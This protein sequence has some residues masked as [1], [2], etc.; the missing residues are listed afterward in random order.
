MKYFIFVLLFF[1]FE[2]NI[3]PQ[4]YKVIS[5]QPNQNE[6]GAVVN[7]LIKVKLSFNPDSSY[8]NDHSFNV[9]GSV[10]GVHTGKVELNGSENELVFTSGTKYIIG[11][12]VSVCFMPMYSG[13]IRRTKSFNWRFTIGAAKKTAAKFSTR[14]EPSL[15]NSDF[16]PVDYDHNG[17]VD[18][19]TPSGKVFYNDGKGNFPV[20]KTHTELMGGVLMPDVNNDGFQDIFN[21]EGGSWRIRFGNKDG[22]YFDGEAVNNSQAIIKRWGDFNGDGYIDVIG[23]TERRFRVYFNDGKGNFNLDT[24]AIENGENA[25]YPPVDVDNDGDLDLILLGWINI[26]VCLNNGE[27]KFGSVTEYKTLGKGFWDD[28]DCQDFNADGFVDAATI[29]TASGGTLIFNDKKGGYVF[30]LADSAK[31]G[32]PE[33]GGFFHIGDF[34]A[35]NK[36]DII[37][38]GVF[39]PIPW[40]SA[41]YCFLYKNL[42][43]Y[44]FTSIPPYGQPDKY[45]LSTRADAYFGN[46]CAADIDCDGALDFVHACYPTLISINGEVMT[47]VKETVQPGKFSLQQN[48]PNPF[49]PSTEIKYELS[50]AG[51]VTLKIYD[52]LGR[53]A[54]V[55]VNSYKNPGEYIEHFNASGLSSGVYICKLQA[56]NLTACKKMVLIK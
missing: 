29:S 51:F 21:N 34:N 55:L 16:I 36:P 20:V 13:A 52:I 24:T 15:S 38:T 49:N 31:F 35:D 10:S 33:S 40:D 25:I 46:G 6:I 18:L 42:G 30:D 9:F 56:G 12:N 11:E 54:A 7:T 1:I 23:W 32:H 3:I 27:G 17:A 41:T 53:E 28:L 5:V 45:V 50:S 26:G 47:G 4:K 14:Q 44:F 19:L 8:I 48:Y 2:Q 22:R 37:L 39:Y 43:G